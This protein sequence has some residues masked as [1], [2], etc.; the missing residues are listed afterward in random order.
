MNGMKK[1]G[2]VVLFTKGEDDDQ[3]IKNALL[4]VPGVQKVEPMMVPEGTDMGMGNTQFM[5]PENPSGP[6]STD[7]YIR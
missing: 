7:G 3:T 6:K 4:K 1:I 5:T 2:Y